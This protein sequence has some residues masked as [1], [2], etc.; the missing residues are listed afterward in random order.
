ML[1]LELEH[2]EWTVERALTTREF[3]LG[4][5]RF[6]EGSVAGQRRV[7]IG[8]A[9]GRPVVQL[10]LCWTMTQEGL[11]RDWGNIEGYR[12]EIEGEPSIT[13]NILFEPPRI[14]G[15]SDEKDVMGVLLVG[16]AMAAVNAIPFVCQA[17]SGLTT[18]AGLPMF[19]ARF[20]V[21]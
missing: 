11:D 5:M 1:E 14:E 2:K 9:H 19:G 13:A 15:L 7:Y 20:A 8:H 4:W 3:D 18:P 21:Q 16:T 6:P 10:V 17:P 12:I